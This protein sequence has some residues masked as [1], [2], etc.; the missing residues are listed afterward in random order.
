M[1]FVVLL[2]AHWLCIGI[3]SLEDSDNIKLE[4]NLESKT[5]PLEPITESV[6]CELFT[7]DND[8]KEDTAD[9]EVKPVEEEADTTDM[10]VPLHVEEGAMDFDVKEKSEDSQDVTKTDNEDED[11]NV[12][13]EPVA[14]DLPDLEQQY[15]DEPSFQED[16]T[17]KDDTIAMDDEV[18]QQEQPSTNDSVT[19]DPSYAPENEELLYEGDV[20]NDSMEYKEGTPVMDEGTAETSTAEENREQ[21]LSLVLDLHVSG[22]ME[23]LQAKEDDQT[24]KG[25]EG[26][27]QSDKRLVKSLSISHYSFRDSSFSNG[28]A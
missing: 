7:A 3:L 15:G 23:D 2:C 12:V 28:R 4:A 14:D 27:S 19:I 6:P 17:A 8:I 10:G 9:E 1:C 21:D 26:A 13:P 16:T 24:A 18:K 5:E 25:G 11:I 20:E 22:E